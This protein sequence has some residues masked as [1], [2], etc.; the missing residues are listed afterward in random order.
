MPSNFCRVIVPVVAALIVL[1]GPAIAQPASNQRPQNPFPYNPNEPVA[2]EM[3]L[4]KAAEYLDGVA[5]FWMKPNSCGACHANFPYLMARPLLGDDANSR[6]AETRKFLKARQP[7]PN[8]FNFDSE[9]VVIA[10]ALSWDDTRRGDKLRK[11]TRPALDRMWARQNQRGWWEEMGC[12]KLIPSETDS[13]HTAA[14]A[15]VAA[16]MAPKKYAR[17][18]LAREGISKLRGAFAK[19]SP[20]NLHGRAV[21]LWASL[22]LDGLLTPAEQQLTVSDLPAFQGRDGGWSMDALK[23]STPRPEIL[24]RPSDG[25]GTGFIVYVLRQAGMP[26]SRSEIARGLAWL[27]ANQRV[28]GRWF[29]PAKESDTEGGVGSRDLYA[30][31]IGTAF[32]ILALSDDPGRRSER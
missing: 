22:H 26:A 29:T 24:E 16:G 23:A 28:S 18:A 9:S 1:P 2:R 15:A 31:N 20:G 27:R 8:G 32:A 14:L 13:Q 6:V 5:R 3:S 19:Y 17:S 4:A 7:N 30:Q 25:Y 21:R 12:G 10:F 11:T